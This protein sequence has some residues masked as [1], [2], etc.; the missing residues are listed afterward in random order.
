LKRGDNL[1][2]GRILVVDDDHLM[3]EFLDETLRRADYSVDLAST[4]D[5]GIEKIK[6][7][8]Y[9]VILSDIRMPKVSGMELLK[10]V[11]ENSPQ[12]KIMLM[13]A[14]GTIENAVE[15]MKSGAFDYITKPFSADDIELKIKRAIEYRRLEWENKLL[16][17]EVSGKYRFEN[18][19][20]KSPQMRRVFE[21][22]DSIAD[23]KS[24]V[25]ITGESGTGK[26][27]IA[28][29]I[30]YNS[31][32]KNELFVPVNCAALPENLMESELFGHEKGAFT[33]AI[34][35]TRGRFE[36]AHRGTLLL[37]EI[38][39]IPPSLQA[40]LLRVLQ[41][42]EFERV[43]SGE[44][45]QVDVRIISTSNQNLPDLIQKGKF[46]EDLYF[47]LNVIPVNIAPLRER[48]EDIIALAGYFLDKYNKENNRDI[49]GISE[50][51]FQMFMEYHWPGNVRELENY[52]ERAVVISKGK[53]LTPEDFPRELLFKTDLS[54]REFKVGQT[55]RDTEK[56]LILKTLESCAGNKTKAAQTLGISVRTLR[57]K[58]NEYWMPKDV[59]STEKGSK[60]S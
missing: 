40:K 53:M 14:Y 1:P 49:K 8:E 37:D 39:E 9:D 41:E 60:N 57:N 54:T 50:K 18:I 19:I 34:K 31:P 7:K 22:V 45:I 33:G 15:A 30:H 38:S 42:R 10:A 51:V 44:S 52:L 2:K 56:A 13:T 59:A 55:V 36:L 11:R 24:S 32:R 26:E 23:S 29:A 4:G 12:S 48:K 35:Q 21:I 43:G 6:S 16:R 58:L 17:S 46:R 3:R 47:R 27:L 20:G 25:L 28:K 5:E